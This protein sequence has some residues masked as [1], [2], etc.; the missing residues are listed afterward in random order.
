ML[1]AT[2]LLAHGW[3]GGIA[4]SIKMKNEPLPSRTFV[5]WEQRDAT[6]T[7]K[8]PNWQGSCSIS[9]SAL[10]DLENVS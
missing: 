4:H 7:D 3:H 1:L 10:I 2:E 5:W 9:N 8:S 6:R